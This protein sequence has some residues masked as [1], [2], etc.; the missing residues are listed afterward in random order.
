MM[1]PAINLIKKLKIK[2]TIH[3]YEHD[4]H[5]THFGREAV[6][7]LDPHLGVLPE[8][9]FKTLVISLDGNEKNLAVCVVPV[10]LQLDLKKTAKAF[11][12]FTY[13]GKVLHCKKVELVD[14]NLAQKVTGYLVGGISP[15]GQKKLL[16]TLID[17]SAEKLTSMFVS[18]GRRGLEIEIAP[19]ELAK[20]LQAQ[21]IEIATDK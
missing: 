11:N 15:L 21:V 19:Q 5:E 4:P 18:G 7:K 8:Q 6:E 12:Q 17:I 13:N 2:F 20:I 3:Q 16:P 10:D 9:V 14:P 1:T